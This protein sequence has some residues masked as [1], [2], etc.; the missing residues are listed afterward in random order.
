MG[1]DKQLSNK[2]NS[3][4]S[5]L[6]KYR[7]I[8]KI[9]SG[10]FGSIYAGI[11]VTDKKPVAIKV[12]K[13]VQTQLSDEAKV[14]NALGKAAGIAQM[15]LYIE[16][17]MNIMVLDML[18]PTIEDLFNYCNRRFS[19]KTVLMLADQL[20]QR[21]EYVHSCKY[22]HRDLKPEN[23]LMGIGPNSN[24]VYIIDFG[25]ASNIRYGNRRGRHMYRGSDSMVGTA[26][27]ASISAHIGFE[28]G[29]R[30]DL[31]SL[32]YIF[33]YLLRGKL[34]WQG[35]GTHAQQRKYASIIEKKVST[36]VELL[37]QG[38][39]EEFGIYIDYCRSLRYDEIPDY[40]YLRKLLRDLYYNMG[41]TYDNN[42][43]WLDPG[44]R[45]GKYQTRS[46][47]N[48]SAIS[49]CNSD[50]NSRKKLDPIKSLFEICNKKRPHI[51]GSK[52][53]VKEA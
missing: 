44:Y 51:K 10:S 32:G 3:P 23:F 2:E 26:R 34:P 24:M 13:S 14:Y 48:V 53:P 12:E 19:L 42:W 28:Q 1:D 50:Q 16:S 9:G 37:I 7:L 6:K 36:P 8:Q 31:E 38:Y 11:D 41:Y 17:E 33:L 52:M 45:L 20:I 29:R 49:G 46:R 22:I 47:S 27:Y 4:E 18:G 15:H 5:K 30:D 43:D 39:P 35:L 40:D 21:V 25:L